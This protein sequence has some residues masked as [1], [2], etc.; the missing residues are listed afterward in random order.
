[1]QLCCGYLDVG[2][3]YHHHD[4]L[5]DHQNHR[6]YYINLYKNLYRR[7]FLLRLFL[8]PGLFLDCRLF[9]IL[10]ESFLDENLKDFSK[11]ILLF[12]LHFERYLFHVFY[13]HFIFERDSHYLARNIYCIQFEVNHVKEQF[14][15]HW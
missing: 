14:V 13:F 6:N 5:K 8:L 4:H 12:N 10:I 11:F 15:E 3:F 1:M 9:N 2:N 7:V